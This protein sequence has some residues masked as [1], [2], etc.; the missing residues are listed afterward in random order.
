P[1][2]ILLRRLLCVRLLSKT[3]LPTPHVFR[4]PST[5]APGLRTSQRLR[6]LEHPT[7]P[8][9]P[10]GDNA[11]N[12]LNAFNQTDDEIATGPHAWTPSQRD[13][14]PLG[15]SFD[16]PSLYDCTVAHPPGRAACSRL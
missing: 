9:L 2:T 10:E 3:R 16:I 8:R 13:L 14:H 15:R 12:A 5:D 4:R 7:A 11:Y 6:A 1:L